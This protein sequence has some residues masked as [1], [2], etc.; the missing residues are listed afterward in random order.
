[1]AKTYQL[2]AEMQQDFPQYL[3]NNY[4]EYYLYPNKIVTEKVLSP[5]VK[6][7]AHQQLAKVFAGSSTPTTHQQQ[8]MKQAVAQAAKVKTNLPKPAAGTDLRRL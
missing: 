7:V 4:L 5:Y 1:W 3:P 6:S 2:M 8:K